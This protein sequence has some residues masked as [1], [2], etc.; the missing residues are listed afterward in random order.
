M[1]T[2]VIDDIVQWDG[3]YPFVDQTPFIGGGIAPSFMRVID[4]A[5]NP[6]PSAVRPFTGSQ[7]LKVQACLADGGLPFGAPQAISNLDVNYARY[8]GGHIIDKAQVTLTAGSGG[9]VFPL[10]TGCAGDEV[11]AVLKQFDTASGAITTVV[12]S[13]GTFSC[14]SSLVT[15]VSAYAL[16]LVRYSWAPIPP[17]P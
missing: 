8:V 6:V 4:V 3:S 16:L 9:G 12:Q 13:N 7:V 11:I 10:G 2:Y 15:D 17:V 14:A 1:N 5:P